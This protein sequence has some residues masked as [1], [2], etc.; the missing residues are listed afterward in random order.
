MSSEALQAGKR[1]IRLAGKTRLRDGSYLPADR[2]GNRL[3]FRGSQS[4]AVPAPPVAKAQPS[5]PAGPTGAPM[6]TLDDMKQMADKKA[7]PLSA[8]LKSDPN[9]SDLLIQVGNLYKHPSVQ[10]SRRLLC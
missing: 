10:G 2:P 8:K 9:N 7:E 6:P 4:P 5:A 3:S 1:R